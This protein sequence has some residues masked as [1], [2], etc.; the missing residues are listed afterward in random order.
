MKIHV[1]NTKLFLAVAS[2][3]VL[4]FTSLN[5]VSVYAQNNE[6][7]I[8][9]KNGVY[10][11]PGKPHLK[12][13]V[14]VHE[15]KQKLTQSTNAVCVDGESEAVV[16]GAGWTLPSSVTYMLNPNSVPSSVGSTNLQTIASNAYAAWSNA[17]AGNVTFIRGS[18]T[19][20]DRKGLDNK[21]IIAW[22]RTSGSA[23]A[24]TYTWYNTSTKVAVETDTI[25]NK[26]FKW[27][28][29]QLGSGVCGVV[30]SYDAQD[31]LTHEL[32][33]WM[34]LNDHYTVAYTE[35]T[36][37]GY[38]SANETK[39]NTLTNGDSVGVNTLY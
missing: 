1:Q 14:F 17:V 15:P 30:G 39:K 3:I 5:L 11:V 35:N 23:L 20:V 2:F 8:P 4:T 25:M 32:G 12:V 31:I 24:V 21:N 37:Y 38:G 16:E 36:M 18:N 29:S 33:H 10:D 7:D 13:R 6:T 22:G 19:T 9:E 28:W 34:G 26:K 27:S